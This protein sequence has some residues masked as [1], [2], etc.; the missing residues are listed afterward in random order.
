VRALFWVLLL[1]S[2]VGCR[3]R[4]TSVAAPRMRIVVSVAPAHPREIASDRLT[5]VTIEHARER[6]ASLSVVDANHRLLA[7]VIAFARNGEA[8]RAI[9]PRRALAPHVGLATLEIRSGGSVV[10]VDLDRE[11]ARWDPSRIVDDDPEATLR[12]VDEMRGDAPN[13]ALADAIAAEAAFAIGRTRLAEIF[14]TRGLGEKHDVELER[15]L[16]RVRI[17]S[18]A[19]AR[20]DYGADRKRLAEI[21]IEQEIALDRALDLRLAELHDRNE[22]GPRKAPDARRALIDVEDVR[23]A[24]MLCRAGAIERGRMLATRTADRAMCAIRTG[25]R[26]T[27][28]GRLAEA[29]VLYENARAILGDRFLPREQRE[30]WYSAAWLAEAR[31]HLGT[32]F[33]RARTACLWVDRSMS[34]E[35]SLDAREALSGNVLSYFLITQRMGLRAKQDESAIAIG[36]LGKGRALATLL[37]GKSGLSVGALGAWFDPPAEEELPR[38]LAAE[39]ARLDPDD[40][41]V[42]YTRLGRNPSG[43]A[44][45]AIGVVTREEAVG[46][47]VPVPDDLDAVIDAHAAA[48]ASADLERAKTLGAQLHA[49]L[50]APIRKKLRKRMLVSPHLALHGV[51]WPALHDGS[52]W[53]VEDQVI[54]RVPP[55]AAYRPREPRRATRWASAIAPP[56]P[57]LGPLPGFE[58]IADPLTRTI[59]PQRDLRGRAVTVKRMLSAL[60]TSDALL[61]AGHA[62]FDAESPL[63]SALLVADG[64]IRASDLL[65][66]HDSIDEVVLV[67]CETGRTTKGPPS[68]ADEA[69]GLPRAFLAGGAR[70]VVG[71]LLEVIDRDAEDFARALLER[72]MTGDLALDVANAQRCMLSGACSSRGPAWGTYVVDVR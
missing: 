68:F 5:E 52:H 39:R 62:R 49:L 30:A 26:E 65:H 21:A 54:A 45:V 9:V 2:V 24:A 67:G 70:Q 47:L 22:G 14:A 11:D 59:A 8:L 53:L 41:V 35:R 37:R 44:E 61:Y 29:E 71:A 60:A 34:I 28:E 10:R 20:N 40:V 15:R 36:E 64:E 46:T 69:I 23:D 27:R 66:L 4:R 48:V 12:A 38:D 17:A 3:H 55:L 56:H 58:S 33:V 51:A 6:S 72:P 7:P 19:E 16:L 1:V 18:V 32:A 43:V 63:D 42:T 31:G 25:D 13:P 50:V 57:P